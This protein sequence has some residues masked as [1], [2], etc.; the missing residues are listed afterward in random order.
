MAACKHVKKKGLGESIQVTLMLGRGSD[1]L[2]EDVT[3]RKPP[4]RRVSSMEI[5]AWR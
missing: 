5:G 2:P 4:A 1:D 3:P